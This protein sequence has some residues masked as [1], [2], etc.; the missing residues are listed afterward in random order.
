[1]P[2]ETPA[3]ECSPIQGIILVPVIIIILVGIFFSGA[4][5]GVERRDKHY[6]SLI[7]DCVSNIPSEVPKEYCSYCSSK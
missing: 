2:K 4:V 7:K 5:F 1:M 3:Q 6:S